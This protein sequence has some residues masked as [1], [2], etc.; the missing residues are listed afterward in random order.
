[1]QA[2]YTDRLPSHRV[3]EGVKASPPPLFH[4]PQTNNIRPRSHRHILLPIKAIS[5]RRSL[6]LLVRVKAPKPL[7]SHS[8]RRGHSAAFIAE[9]HN[10]PS[11]RKH[12]P[13]RRSLTRFRNLPNNLPR[14]NINRPQNLQPGIAWHIPARPT[15]VSSPRLPLRIRLPIDV[16]FIQRL[17]VIQPRAGIKRS[18]EPIRGAFNRRTRLCTLGGR[19]LIRDTNRPSVLTDSSRPSQLLRKRFPE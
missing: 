7:T 2:N 6:Q 9:N 16:A 14:L 1:M 18:R 17:H 11:G 10:S 3:N 15:L 5:H 4:Q 13:P 12:A 8:I 19:L